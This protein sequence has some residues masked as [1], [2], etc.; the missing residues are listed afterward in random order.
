M[1]G[2]RMGGVLDAGVSLQHRFK[3]VSEQ[4]EEAD[5][6]PKREKRQEGRTEKKAHGKDSADSAEEAGQCPSQSLPGADLGKNLASSPPMPGEIG[7]NIGKKSS[8]QEEQEKVEA[9]RPLTQEEKPTEGNADI[10]ESEKKR[11]DA[12]AVIPFRRDQEIGRSGKE[13]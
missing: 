9:I 7:K 3:K 12:F 4:A 11:S 6:E 5:Q 13:Q 10:E 8:H 2:D 1:P